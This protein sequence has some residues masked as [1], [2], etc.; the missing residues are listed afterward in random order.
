MLSL[1]PQVQVMDFVI[2]KKILFGGSWTDNSVEH[3][4]VYALS[5]SVCHT[6]KIHKSAW[7]HMLAANS[8]GI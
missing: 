4:Q 7:V 3:W 8:D 5:H 2:W 6:G 1:E